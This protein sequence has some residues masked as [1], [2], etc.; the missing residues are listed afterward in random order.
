[1]IACLPY[2]HKMIRK[3]SIGFFFCLLGGGCGLLLAAIV[4]EK[5]LVSAT[6]YVTIFLGIVWAFSM[7][8]Y[9]RLSDLT[10]LPGI[11]YRQH[12]NLE[13][14]IRNRLRR[15]WWRAIAL[16]A[17]GLAANLPVLLSNGAIPIGSWAFSVA[18]GAFALAIFL[19]HLIWA[20][21][22]DIRGLRS[23]AKEMER[24]EQ[25]RLAQLALLRKED[26]WE[27]DPM[28]KGL[29]SEAEE[30]GRDLH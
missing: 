21:L 8:V 23:K 24:K 5:I 20:E 30:N 25:Q 4:P 18:G 9:S 3:V 16:G 1:M 26:A 11:D 15:F 22:E 27:A 29:D 14:E 6:S 7:N 2:T 17:I 28:L 19:L 13:R 12:R 10:D